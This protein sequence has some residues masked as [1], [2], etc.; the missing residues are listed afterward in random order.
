MT[1]RLLLAVFATALIAFAIGRISA[2]DPARGAPASV[3]E[4]AG[5]DHAAIEAGADSVA[6]LWTCPMHP[7]IQLP[8]F[9][10]CPICGMDLVPRAAGGDDDPRRLAMSP[11]AIALAGIISE[12]ARRRNVTRPV[13]MVGKIDY[14]ETAVRT[15]SA[16]VAGRLERLFVDAQGVPVARG[17]HLVSIYSPDLLLAQDELLVAKRELA[18]I[19]SATSEFLAESTRG[20]YRAARDKL[21]LFGLSAGQV[22]ELERR[23]VADDHVLINSP[24]SGVVID[25]LVD[26]GAYV[27]V[28]EPIYRIADLSRLWVLLDAYEQDLPWVRYGQP[29]RLEVEAMPGRIVEGTVSFVD[30]FIDEHTRTAKVRVQVDN[31]T[32]LLKPG[33]FVHGVVLARLGPGGALIVDDVAG[34]WVSPMHPEIVKDGPGVCDVCGMDLVPAEELGLVSEPS[35]GERPLVVPRSA[36]LVTGVRAI[37]YV[38]VPGAER[39]TYEGREVVLGPTAGDDVIIMDGLEEGERVVVNGAFRV[40]SAMQIV[41]KP[42]MMSMPGER[43]APSGPHVAVFVES[44]GAVYDAALALQVALAGDDELAARAVFVELE[45]VLDAPIASGLAASERMIWSEERARLVGAVRE[46]RRAAD[47]GELRVAFEHVSLSVLTLALEFGHDRPGVL[48]EAHCP[49]A[50][51]DRGASWLQAGSEILNPYFGAAMLRCGDVRT[52]LGDVSHATPTV[53]EH[54]HAEPGAHAP[55]GPASELFEAYLVLQEALAADAAAVAE[56][57]AEAL[58][59]AAEAAGADDVAS[60]LARRAERSS[61]IQG[62]RVLFAPISEAMIARVGRAGQPLGETLHVVH[63]PMAFDDQGA[64]WIQRERTVANPYFGASMLRCGRVTEDLEPAGDR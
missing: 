11:A 50:F 42:S 64:N 54:E 51:D 58:H 15:I 56:Q 36:V 22:D 4:H 60:V 47:I 27:R 24:S 17:D 6:T 32:G 37:V 46:A 30:P 25:K 14:D 26:E 12:P 16:W 39:P 41:A 48:I 29:V 3:D 18:G 1:A 53:E 61:D 9:G 2:P 43:R 7:Q 23:S 21:L 20:G 63:C 62:L 49:M 59:A 33:M 38:D 44:L 40:D 19:T 5:H 8:E 55:H 31:S 10:D 57:A 35:D 34:K 52:Q 45:T 13:R 28:G